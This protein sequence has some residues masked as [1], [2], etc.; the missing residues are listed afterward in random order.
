MIGFGRM[1]SP[2]ETIEQTSATPGGAGPSKPGV[3]LVFDAGKP[4]YQ[5]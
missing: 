4:A 5:R 1:S 2:D 3:V